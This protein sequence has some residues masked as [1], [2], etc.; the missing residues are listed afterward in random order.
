[1]KKSVLYSILLAPALT[2]LPFG[3]VTLA[4]GVKM[5]HTVVAASGA[6]APSGGNYIFFL[7]AR[8]STRPE[9]VFD[10]FLGGPSHTGVFVG[11]GGTTTAIALGGN[12]EPAAGN[13]GLVMSPFITRNGNVVF[14]ANGN[15]IF[16]S[17][18]REFLR[19]VQSGDLA[20]GG[21][22]VSPD[23]STYVAN[24]GGAIAYLALV[25]DSTATQGIFRTDGTETVA[26]ARNDIDPPTG[27]S[28]TALFV[29]VINNRGEVAFGA[30]MTGGAANF[31]IFR[32]D[33]GNL[34]PVFVANQMAPGGGTFTDFGHPV[35][36]AQGQIAAVG[37]LTEDASRSGL[38]VGDGTNAVA[39]AI[40]GQAAPKGGNYGSRRPFS[41]HRLNDRGEVAFRAGLTGGTSSEG[42]FRGNGERTTA[43]ALAGTVAP[44]TTGMFESFDD[45]KL[46]NNGRVAFIASLA[47]GEGGVDFSNN[48][49]IWVGTSDKDLQLVVRTGELI[50][51]KVLT[52]LV[53][54][55]DVGNPFD[56]NEDGVVWIGSFQP[57]GA[58]V[59]FSSRMIGE[60]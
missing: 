8:L 28:F 44:G 17:N 48:V 58:A 33:G 16:T 21:G 31:G 13:F 45:I 34:I 37:L 36:N 25:S 39:I 15:S 12:P 50:G 52:R 60:N 41:S 18:R 35:I 55:N 49:G 54:S 46:G 26:I 10:A 24:D 42:I 43:V 56:M 40:V 19:L 30:E 2:V 9:V 11:R 53:T 4:S 5:R 7:N 51:G 1:M 20:P 32:G 14:D 57:S 23:A 29:P 27:G 6:A 38:F 22:T 47:V 59:V 3:Q